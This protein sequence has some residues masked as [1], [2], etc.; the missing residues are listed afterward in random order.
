MNNKYYIKFSSI[1]SMN[2]YSIYINKNTGYY[3]IESINGVIK[4]NG[5]SIINMNECNYIQLNNF[6][7]NCINEFLNYK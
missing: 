3:E 1:K 5:Y 6:A 7:Y 2:E 4:L